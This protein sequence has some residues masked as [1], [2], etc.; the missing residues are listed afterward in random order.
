MK[1]FAFTSLLLGALMGGLAS[2]ATAADCAPC[3]PDC[4]PC[5]GFGTFKAGA[6]WLYWKTHT[7]VVSPTSIQTTY[8]DGDASSKSIQQKFDYKSGYRVN[9]GYE[10][11]GDLWEVN[12]SY[13]YVPTRAS[14]GDVFIAPATHQAT[15]LINTSNTYNNGI[16]TATFYHGKTSMNLS[17]VDVDISRTI[18][19]GESL[20]FSLRPH[21]GFRGV[22][23]DQKYHENVI[24]STSN[25]NSTN[26]GVSATKIDF[27]GYGVEGGLWSE[28]KFCNGLS[29]VGHVGG[30]ILY[31]RFKQTG[32]TR[33]TDVATDGTTTTPYNLDSTLVTYDGTPTVDYF[34]GLQYENC[35]CNTNWNVHIGWE[36]HIWFNLCEI[37]VQVT[38]GATHISYQGLTLG[39]EVGF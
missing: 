10:L 12:A 16:S 7:D 25:T 14:S 31:S 35:F 34:V 30:S 27:Q 22:W 33:E 28:W 21:I 17:G 24:L 26:Y 5:C 23:I 6:D 39:L 9:V 19:C 13:T 20:N 2:Q 38:G 15:Q 37:N 32:F 18:L 4:A 36:Q 11:P 3:Q 29:I 1:K 8:T